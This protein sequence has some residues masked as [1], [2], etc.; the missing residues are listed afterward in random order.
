MYNKKYLDIDC[1]RII[2]AFFVIFN[3]TNKLGFQLYTLY[4]MSDVRYWAYLF[5]SV[6]CKF[7]V[8]LFFMITGAVF[9]NRDSEN[10][11]YLFSHRILKLF[12]VLIF[13]SLFYYMN[14]K[15]PG[16]WKFNSVLRGGINFNL[17]EFLSVLYTYNWN[18][19]FW[20]LYACIPMMMTIPLLQRIAKSLYDRDFLYLYLLYA[21][22]QIII[23]MVQFILWKD[24]YKINSN[25]SISWLCCN[26]FVFPLSGYFFMNRGQG[27]WSIKRIAWLW[28]INIATIIISCYMTYIKAKN[29]GDLYNQTYL[30][31]FVIINCV[32]IFITFKWIF[33]HV[34]ISKYLEAIINSVGSCTFGIYILH[35][36]FLDWPKK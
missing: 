27:Y 26:I 24:V 4:D 2:A 33:N 16:F 8:P 29:F 7:S 34:H 28:V 3:H 13:W 35:I 5:I 17:K 25:F 10:I 32:A 36:F 14:E 23:P 9:L 21:I 19:P 31:Q 22:F 20:Y 11:K 15:N 30:S 12:T 6:F 18:T 1:M